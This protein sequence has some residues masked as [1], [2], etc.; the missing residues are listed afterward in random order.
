MCRPSR[1]SLP[2]TGWGSLCWLLLGQEE[3]N[4]GLSSLC[5]QRGHVP[6]WRALPGSAQGV[7]E[8]RAPKGWAAAPKGRLSSQVVVR[9]R[10]LLPRNLVD[11]LSLR[12]ASTPLLCPGH[13]CLPRSGP[14]N[15]CGNGANENVTG[16]QKWEITH[17]GLSLGR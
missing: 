14:K 15:L 16:P 8:E 4:E 2:P 7:C 1:S 10:H 12:S 3:G 5:N 11:G 6:P 17:V 13:P 9:E